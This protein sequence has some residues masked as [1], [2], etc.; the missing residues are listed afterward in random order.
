MTWWEC[1]LKSKGRG[2]MC[3]ICMI[4]GAHLEQVKLLKYFE[5]VV[6]KSRPADD[7]IESKVMQVGK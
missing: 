3:M 7:D 2:E 6:N 1:L 5:C 4:Q